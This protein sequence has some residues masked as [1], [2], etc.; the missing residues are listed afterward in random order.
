MRPSTEFL[1]RKPSRLGPNRSR[2]ASNLHSKYLR[3]SRTSNVLSTLKTRSS[4]SLAGSRRSWVIHSGQFYSNSHQPSQ[5][6]LRRLR[7]W[8]TPVLP[9]YELHGSF[10]MQAGGELAAS[11]TSTCVGSLTT[12]HADSGTVPRFLRFYENIIL[13]YAR[14]GLSTIQRCIRLK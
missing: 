10:G 4:F 14:I 6:T 13:P 3:T 8:L 7:R 5:K 2:K 11:N 12:T 9:V 1:A